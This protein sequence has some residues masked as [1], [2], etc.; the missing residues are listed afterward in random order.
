MGQWENPSGRQAEAAGKDRSRA[1]ER[2]G[3]RSKDKGDKNDKKRDGVRKFP[4][5]LFMNGKCERGDKCAFSHAGDGGCIKP[6]EKRKGYTEQPDP[7]PK[8]SNPAAVADNE[9]T[10]TETDYSDTYSD[11]DS[12]GVGCSYAIGIKRGS[13]ASDNDGEWTDDSEGEEST[14]HFR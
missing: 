13:K 6:G 14:H 9:E 1:P 11:T 10:D 8:Q 7:R 2:N 5:A 4:C 3:D 12:D